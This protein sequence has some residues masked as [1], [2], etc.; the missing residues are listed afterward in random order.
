ML[1]SAYV[2]NTAYLLGSL[3]DLIS[4]ANTVF[5]QFK[6]FGLEIN[7]DRGVRKS[8]TEEMI[9]TASKA[10]N[11][12]IPDNANTKF[13]V[14]DGFVTFTKNFQYLGSWVASYLNEKKDIKI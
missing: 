11:T 5:E 10:S 4:G 2:E 9:L 7:I 8:R 6:R 13:Q 14:A 3:N 12:P 1:F